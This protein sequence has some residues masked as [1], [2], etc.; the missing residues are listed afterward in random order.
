MEL[1]ELAGATATASPDLSMRKGGGFGGA[2]VGVDC[3]RKNKSFRDA[4]IAYEPLTQ[5]R[6]RSPLAA[7]GAGVAERPRLPAWWRGPLSREV[8][9]AFEPRCGRVGRGDFLQHGN[10]TRSTAAIAGPTGVDAA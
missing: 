7:M 6:P 1:V 2:G 5:Y 9:W 3:P 4:F 8:K 10:E